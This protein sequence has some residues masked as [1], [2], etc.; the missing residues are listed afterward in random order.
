MPRMRKGRVSLAEPRLHG[1]ELRKGAAR[2][3]PRATR[4]SPGGGGRAQSHGAPCVPSRGPP[5]QVGGS[6]SK[7]ALQSDPRDTEAPHPGTFQAEMVHRQRFT[8]DV[9]LPPAT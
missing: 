6:S 3:S 8:V 2:K 4:H 7:A 5:G 9:L 1:H